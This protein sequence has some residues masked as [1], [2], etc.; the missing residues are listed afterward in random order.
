MQAALWEAAQDAPQRRDTAAH[1]ALTHGSRALYRRGCRCLLC[2]H[3]ESQYRRERRTERVDATPARRHLEQLAACGVGLTQAARLSRIP[4]TTLQ[5]LREGSRLTTSASL[6]AAV[7]AIPGA[8]APG[9]LT[10][11]WP[12]RRLLAW[13]HLEGFTNRDLAQRLG[14]RNR[15]LQFVWRC[16]TYR[17]AARV[18]ALYRKVAQV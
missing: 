16:C 17:N 6:V 15:H 2:A 11:A 13:F 12:L 4:R 10:K 9:A 1:A 8:P 14:Y 3:A 5:H 7:L 18:R